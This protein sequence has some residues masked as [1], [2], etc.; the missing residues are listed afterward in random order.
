[1]GCA[2]PRLT[3]AMQRTA[4]P[5]GVN[6][7]SFYSASAQSARRNRGA[8]SLCAYLDGCAQRKILHADGQLSFVYG[9]GKTKQ[10][11]GANDENHGNYLLV[12]R[13]LQTVPL[14]E[15]WTLSDVLIFP[16]TYSPGVKSNGIFASPIQRT[17]S[18]IWSTERVH[19]RDVEI[20][21][22]SNLLVL[23]H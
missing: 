11:E 19:R 16:V 21:L 6:C 18:L 1:M 9:S 13:W 17:K 10:N 7:V 2:S 20:H 3:K 22:N 8:A 23:R 15:C 14:C 12:Y 5:D 4:A